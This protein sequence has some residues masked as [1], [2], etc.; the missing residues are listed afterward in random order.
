MQ[1]GFWSLVQKW[2]AD[3]VTAI[4]GLTAHGVKRGEQIKGKKGGSRMAMLGI[5]E[6][7]RD[8]EI[9]PDEVDRGKPRCRCLDL[10]TRFIRKEFGSG[11]EE[12]YEE[13][14]EFWRKYFSA[15]PQN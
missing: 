4:Q 5:Y 7:A 10:L 12:Q 6:L 3:C 13:Y 8:I 1:G 2:H 9:H 11:W 15:P 14:E